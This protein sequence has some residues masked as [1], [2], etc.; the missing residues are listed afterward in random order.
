MTDKELKSS[1]QRQKVLIISRLKPFFSS[2]VYVVNVTDSVKD[3]TGVFVGF[4]ARIET[5]YKRGMLLCYL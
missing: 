2:Y 4:K 5:L 3:T 1:H